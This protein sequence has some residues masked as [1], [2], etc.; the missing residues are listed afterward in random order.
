[1]LHDASTML[2]VVCLGDSITGAMPDV[3]YLDKYAK[4][5]DLLQLALETHLGVGKAAVINRG[6]AGN[7]STQALARVDGQVLP[8]RPDVVIVLIGG[9]N[10]GNQSDV[11]TATARLRDDLTAIVAKVKKAGSKIL[12]LQYPTPRA[13]RM[14]QIWTHLNAG[15][16]VIAEVARRENVATLELAPA[17]DEAAKTH[18]LDE[19]ASAID[20]VHLN[21]YGEIVIARAVFFELRRL[22]WLSP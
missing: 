16:P 20:G 7:S 17:F 11:H 13:E 3:R 2:T 9:N 18:P 5:S 21:P 10:F 15:N 12:L 6:H 19:L 8:L 22:G 1:M 4:W 14:E